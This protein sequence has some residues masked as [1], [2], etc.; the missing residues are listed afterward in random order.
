MVR[1]TLQCNS[2]ALKCDILSEHFFTFFDKQTW[3]GDSEDHDA[4]HRCDP[5][6]KPGGNTIILSLFY[7]KAVFYV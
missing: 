4:S 5:G 6:S 7:T 2:V 3:G 1:F